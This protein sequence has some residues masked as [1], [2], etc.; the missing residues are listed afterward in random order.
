[1][2]AHA[3]PYLEYMQVTHSGHAERDLRFIVK[4]DAEAFMDWCFEAFDVCLVGHAVGETRL[5]SYWLAFRTGGG[6]TSEGSLCKKSAW[7]I[8]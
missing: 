3:P 7:R 6:E 2:K 4:K 5:H 8:P 1:M